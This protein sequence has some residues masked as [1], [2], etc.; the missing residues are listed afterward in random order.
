[1]AKLLEGMARWKMFRKLFGLD[2]TIRSVS[3]DDF[4]D[5]YMG[6][7]AS[8]YDAQMQFQQDRR[9]AYEDYEEM[10]TFGLISSALE[11][12]QEEATQYDPDKG[13]AMW[14]ST[15][16]Q[17][18]SDL[19]DELGQ[20][21]N[22]EE[23]LPAQARN[24][25][26]FGDHFEQ[27]A[28]SNEEGIVSLMYTR[29]DLVSRVE[30]KFARLL[31][32]APG[33]VEPFELEDDKLPEGLSKAWDF[34]HF[35]IMGSRLDSVHGD[36]LLLPARRDW[37]QL[38]IIEDTLVLYRINRAPDRF[39]YYI[40]VGTQPLEE[41]FNT[42]RKWRQ[43]IKKRM[44]F[45]PSQKIMR[46]EYNPM[47]ADEDLFWPTRK[48][49]NSRIE[50][51]PGSGP[52]GDIYDVEYFRNK[53]FAALRVPKAY[54][55]F[56]GDVNAKATLL[57]QDVR[58]ARTIKRLQRALIIGWTRAMQIHMVL[59]SNDTDKFD[60]L[61]PENE[62]Q[63]QM[64]PSSYLDD[65]QRKELY[66]LRLD[67]ASRLADMG[68]MM[69]LK[70]KSWLTWV[71]H[72]FVGLADEKVKEIL[73]P[74]DSWDMAPG[75]GSPRSA[76]GDEPGPSAPVP[77]SAPEGD[78]SLTPSEQKDISEALKKIEHAG[79]LRTL[80]R[81]LHGGG[82]RPVMVDEHELV[83]TLGE[84]STF[85]DEKGKADFVEIRKRID[86]EGK[87]VLDARKKRRADIVEARKHE[88]EQG[89]KNLKDLLEVE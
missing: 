1:M 13:A 14:I 10:D 25:A 29:P 75:D 37:R 51:F 54:M 9:R 22:R 41:Q 15:K 85:T 70:R 58:F 11:I 60:P 89:D 31:G 47:T 71:L 4:A 26:K 77:G 12:Y 40:D 39:I 62:F 59:R 72:E 35:R 28:Y 88:N 73:T 33:I 36:S 6:R 82:E 7:A 50:K 66:D 24:V 86:V 32:F 20:N 84:V 44:A 56:E 53:I 80:L 64:T 76:I 81:T 52:V 19:W 65:L 48:D 34:L 67:L 78:E 17:K 63:L 21:V 23:R 57:Q 8:W 83:P 5:P 68:R 16:N 3:S 18:V 45:D 79:V 74:G 49:S 46:Q 42:V 38:K 2:K 87:K 30:D 43:F 27:I 69:N 61:K 55:G